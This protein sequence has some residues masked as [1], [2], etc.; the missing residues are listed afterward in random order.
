MPTI[1]PAAARSPSPAAPGKAASILEIGTG[2]PPF[3]AILAGSA[4][5]AP[6][7]AL[8]ARQPLAVPGTALP[9]AAPIPSLPLPVSPLAVPPLVDLPV[10][11]LPNPAAVAMPGRVADKTLPLISVVKTSGSAEAPLVGPPE[12]KDEGEAAPTPPIALPLPIV[13][14]APVVAKP[15]VK[16]A[17]PATTVTLATTPRSG[18]DM[19]WTPV[20]SPAAAPPSAATPAPISAPLAPALGAGPPVA[21]NGPVAAPLAPVHP[22]ALDPLAPAAVAP[23]P[24]PK[25]DTPRVTLQPAQ[26]PAITPPPMVAGPALQVFGAAISAARREQADLPGSGQAPLPTGIAVAPTMVATIADASGQPLL[27]MRQER[28]PQAMISQI[29]HLRDTAN[30]SDTRI[31]LIPDA[32]GTIDVAVAREGD[33]INVRFT[34]EQP[35]TRALIQDAQPR[36]AAIAEERGLRLGQTAVDGGGTTGSMPQQQQRQPQRDATAL[37]VPR[38]AAFTS[39]DHEEAGSGRLA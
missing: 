22:A 26:P 28:W 19:R 32:L 24:I 14:P 6:D 4:E 18:R 31:R 20:S 8:V 30:A 15:D 25:L 1:A 2:A 12:P 13:L 23:S 36:L 34:A 33:T 5:T 3:A 11:T 38:R 21:P 7:V 39:Q 10:A 35:A 17:A 16:T 29:E 9:E 27:D 37:P